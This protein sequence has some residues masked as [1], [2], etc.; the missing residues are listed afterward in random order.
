[1]LQQYAKDFLD[2]IPFFVLKQL[3][4]DAAN[5]I[6]MTEEEKCRVDNLLIGVDS[7]SDIPEEQD[8]ESA[9]S[10]P[11]QVALVEGDGFFPAGD[12]QRR[13]AEIDS[14]LK[15]LLPTE[16]FQSIA[17]TPLGNNTPQQVCHM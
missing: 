4:S 1:M 9:L 11:F 3:A 12:E 17:S 15:M 7:L 14:R 5:L 13:L 16:D 6:A 8:R 2:Y 10:N